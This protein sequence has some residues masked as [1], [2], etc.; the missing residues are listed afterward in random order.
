[1][2]C[3]FQRHTCTCIRFI[4]F[5]DLVH[6]SLHSLKVNFCDQ[7]FFCCLYI[8][9]NHWPKF[10]IDTTVPHEYPLPKLLKIFCSLSRCLLPIYCSFPHM[11]GFSLASAIGHSPKIVPDVREFAVQFGQFVRDDFQKPILYGNA[12]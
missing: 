3:E 8:S 10:K 6:L 1:M 2:T 4:Q 12:R 9:V 11:Q 7:S 5:S